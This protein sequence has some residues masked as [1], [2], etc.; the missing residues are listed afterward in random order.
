MAHEGIVA[1]CPDCHT[2]EVTVS[3]CR[4]GLQIRCANHGCATRITLM[5][6]AALSRLMKRLPEPGENV[7]RISVGD[8]ECKR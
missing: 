8:S 3:I 7:R 6:P 4:H 2:V 1:V 5:L